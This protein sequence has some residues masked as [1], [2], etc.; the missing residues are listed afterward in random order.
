MLFIRPLFILFTCLCSLISR[1][2]SLP[3]LKPQI[4]LSEVGDAACSPGGHTL[5]VKNLG[6]NYTLI[7]QSS[8]I[9]LGTMQVDIGSL[10]L[11]GQ[12]KMYM[13]DNYRFIVSTGTELL[14]GDFLSGKT[15]TV[16]NG[17][18]FPE[19]IINYIALPLQPERLLI[20]L[21]KYQVDKKGSV[22]FFREGANQQTVYDDTRDCR[23]LLY[24]MRTKSVIRSVAVPFAVTAFAVRADRP[25]T[26]LA[27]TFD[28]DVLEIDTALNSNRVFHAF[29]T[30]VHSLAGGSGMIVAV[31]NIAPK[32][33]SDNGDEYALFYREATKEK[34]KLVLP[35]ETPPSQEDKTFKIS[36]SARIKKLFTGD[37]GRD[38]FISYAFSRLLKVSLPALDTVS[39]PVNWG[40]ADFYC[41]N[42]DSTR[43]IAAV[44]KEPG[45][46][47]VSGDLILFDPVRK[48]GESFFRKSAGQEKYAQLYKLFDRQGNYHI[49]GLKRDFFKPDTLVVYSSNRNGPAF[50]VAP[51]ESFII[52]VRDSALAVQNTGSKWV[53]GKLRLENIRQPVYRF[54]LSA[55]ADPQLD[56][57]PAALFDIVFDSRKA[58]MNDLPFSMDAFQYAGNGEWMITG[59]T[60]VAKASP[61]R[62]LLVD[63]HVKTLFRSPETDP[64]LIFQDPR[65]SPS[66]KWLAFHYTKGTVETLEIWNWRLNKKVFAQNFSNPGRLH[67]YSFDRTQD[68]LF[69]SKE[70]NRR[71]GEAYTNEIYQA[72]P[73]AERPQAKLVFKDPSVFSFETDIAADRIASEAYTV[74]QLHRLS[75]HTLLWKTLPFSDGFSVRHVP[76]GFALASEEELHVITNNADH[77]YFTSYK[78]FKPVEILNNYLYRGEKTAMNNLAFVLNGK[79]YLPGDFDIWFNR[80][81]SVL[82]RSGSRNTAFNELIGKTVARRYRYFPAQ[83]LRQVLLKSPVVDIRDKERIPEPVTASSLSLHITARAPE[84]DSIRLVQVLDNGVPVFAGN[85]YV[86]NYPLP[87]VDT[88][89]AIPL[90]RGLNRLQLLAGTRSGFVSA[91]EY[92]SVSAEFSAPAPRTWFVG[93]GV[94]RYRDSLMNLRYADK[95]IRDLAKAFAEKYP[96]ASVD[97]FLNETATASSILAIRKKLE[98]TGVEDRVVISLSGHGLIDSSGN[99]F[100]ATHDMDFNQVSRYGL[101]YPAIESLLSGI[102]AR[103]RLLWIDACHSGE[104]DKDA[105]GDTLSVNNNLKAYGPQKGGIIVAKSTT[106]G[107]QNSFELMRELFSDVGNN[108][109]TVVISAAGGLEYALEDANWQNG[110][111]TWC[112]KKGLLEKA[113]DANL[114][115]IITVNELKE[116]VSRS[117]EA[118]TGGRQKPTSRRESLEYDWELW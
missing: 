79:G 112:V 114:D 4:S 111:F 46:F 25:E 52:G 105:A 48:K 12:G 70:V 10:G 39:V 107:L 49:L 63:S 19:F 68:I 93:V 20:A 7:D 9:Q 69:F 61:H 11:P 67:Y 95:D 65:L 36:P 102:P 98:Q 82:L 13:P 34:K 115:S 84:G 23:L 50:L 22:A 40:A 44:D 80:P 97:T 58:E 83:D 104:L 17:I 27:G 35:K 118:L 56:T 73:A 41:F 33:I 38:L 45:I 75:D 78:N 32:F 5:L 26:V 21:K 99:F 54:H 85:G 72:D 24:D 57:L 31:P 81:D 6:N 37:G 18:R 8:K 1:S 106:V 60:P 77:L 3:A 59:Y 89:L 16:F 53:I 14:S 28:G 66:G 71:T 101:S 30:P 103:K 87:L 55:Y 90:S 109:G 86:F 100:F 43:L 29:E 15:D 113:A 2:Q 62:V 110:V 88:V 117:V 42:R 92:L 116:Y 47:S 108:N 74:L 96:G 64:G 76:G 91:P 94:S 51:H